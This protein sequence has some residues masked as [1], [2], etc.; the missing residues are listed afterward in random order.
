M[1]EGAIAEIFRLYDKI[2]I[3]IVGIGAIVGDVRSMLID[4]GYVSRAELESLR[5]AGA[6]GD[7]F[8]YFIDR[9]GEI[10]RTELYE[11]LITIGLP[12]IRKVPTTVGVATGT[13]K[14]QAVAAAV[15]GGFVNTLIVDSALARALLALPAV[16]HGERGRGPSR[17]RR[18][19]PFST[20]G[21][22]P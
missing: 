8:S 18:R 19:R 21:D 17:S 2:D 15:R 10:V 22:D 7:V 6:V 3:A 1:R 13:A 12:Q 16:A 5:K 9:N 20:A 4:S 11:R 14:A